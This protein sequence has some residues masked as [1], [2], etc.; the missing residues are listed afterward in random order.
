M[1]YKLVIIIFR[2][3]FFF[4]L[5]IKVKGNENIPSEE[6]AILVANHPSLI[7]GP[8]LAAVTR[9]KLFTYAKKEVFNTRI[10]RSFLKRLGGIPVQSEKSNRELLTKTKDILKSR[11]LIL[12]FPEGKANFSS[13]PGEFKNS[14]VKLALQFNVPIIPISI[15][16]SDKSLGKNQKF[17]RPAK[18]EIIYGEPIKFKVGKERM[19]KDEIELVSKEIKNIIQKRII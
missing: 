18:I 8:L 11:K 16:G 4:L 5:N 6:G 15:N 17:P 1:F 12:I 7:D 3:Y 19:T 10:K 13:E 9:R 2:F 14:F